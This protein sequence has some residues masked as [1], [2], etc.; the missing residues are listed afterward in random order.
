MLKD[1]GMTDE[2]LEGLSEEQIQ[3]IMDI[4]NRGIP[5]EEQRAQSQQMAE[6]YA[7]RA[8]INRGVIT[9]VKEGGEIVD[10]ERVIR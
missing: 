10:Q 9:A 6:F 3:A 5:T 2:Q 7:D 8:G 1:Q 4:Y